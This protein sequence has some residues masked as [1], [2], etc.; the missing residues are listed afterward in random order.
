MGGVYGVAQLTKIIEALAESL[1][2][3]SKLKHNQGIFVL[4]QLADE[5]TALGGIDS[6]E[7]SKEIKELDEA[8]RAT[9]RAVLKAKLVLVNP[10]MEKKL[11]DGADLLDEVVA[12]GVSAI[13]SAKQFID[14]GKAI[15]A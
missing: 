3:F 6:E 14:R 13:V 5:F 8:D 2:V 1:N 7:L 12:W 9:L 10:A 4:F 11:E 15:L